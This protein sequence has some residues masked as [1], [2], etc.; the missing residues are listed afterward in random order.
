MARVRRPIIKVVYDGKNIT[1]DISEYLVSLTYTDKAHGE[2]DEIDIQL[3]NS[4]GRWI[5]AWIPELGDKIQIEIGYEGLL[6]NCGTFSIDE[7]SAGG[8]PDVMNLRGLAAPINAQIRTK[9][10]AAYESQTLRQIAEAVAAANGLTLV[11]GTLRTDKISVN[12]TEEKADIEA[13][14]ALIREAVK[15]KSQSFYDQVTI[16][17]YTRLSRAALSIETKGK[18]K[19]SAYILTTLTVARKAVFNAGISD[20][21]AASVFALNFAKELDKIAVDLVNQ[22][23][24]RTTSKLDGIRIDRTT[25]NRETDL[26][27]LRRLG[28]LYGFLFSVRDNQLI[29]IHHSDVEKADASQTLDLRNLI[30][31]SFK[32]KSADTYS[33]AMVKHHNPSTKEVVEYDIDA[34][35]DPESVNFDQEVKSDVLEIRSRSE[36]QQQAEMKAKAALH[37]KNSKQQEGDFTVIGDPLLVAGNN[38]A[39]SGLG[40]L[41]GIYTINES[42]HTIDKNGG[43]VTSVNCKKIDKGYSSA[44]A[45]GTGTGKPSFCGEKSCL[46]E[47]A[48]KLRAAAKVNTGAEYAKIAEPVYLKLQKCGQSLVDKGD[49]KNGNFVLT[50]IRVGKSIVNSGFLVITPNVR[51]VLNCFADELDKISNSLKC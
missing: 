33:S 41:S 20:F 18:R 24:S 34:G 40:A 13:S 16:P 17:G 27:F 10:S 42:K 6:V 35:D 2:S 47:Q 26:G 45:T 44:A 37:A 36:N 12:F 3:E 5:D 8:P 28:E 7:I 14:A 21:K 22:N 11:D 9:K 31:Y 49:V 1:E 30:S 4:D 48:A 15:R 51:F 39:L 25:Q 19:E 23:Y 29:F 38:F 50:N 32:K 43:Y 46:K